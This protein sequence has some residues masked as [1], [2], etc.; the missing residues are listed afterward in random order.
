M[1]RIK[2]VFAALL[3]LAGCSVPAPTTREAVQYAQQYY[4]AVKAGDLDKAVRF[5]GGE[6]P[7]EAWRADLQDTLRQHGALQE[8]KLVR[9]DM[10]TIYSGTLY[11]VE[12][13]VHYAKGIVNE[14]MTLR[15]P[16]NGG[17][18]Q[19]VSV[20]GENDVK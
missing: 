3:L 6:K 16:V 18:L 8:Y 1:G 12:A 9:A 20:R 11:V 19:I 2:Y 4:D 10:N 17:E 13:R 15:E 7:A 14:V 5:L